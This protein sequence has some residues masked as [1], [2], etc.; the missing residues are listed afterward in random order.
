M[1]S[2]KEVAAIEGLADWNPDHPMVKFCEN[3]RMWEKKARQIACS[4]GL[5]DN[6][7]LR[8]FDLGCGFG[9]FVR[10]CTDL[11]HDAE[12]L[13]RREPLMAGG[14]NDILGNR[15]VS[16]GVQPGYPVPVEFQDADLITMFGVSLRRENGDYW[17]ATEYAE[18]TRDILSRLNKGGRFVIRP[19]YPMTW[20]GDEWGCR[21]S[22]WAT[23]EPTENTITVRPK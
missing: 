16:G 6:R 12:G 13:D 1:L 5:D 2:D 18:L 8:I 17:D 14:A 23:I 20:N 22:Q 9:Y 19:N 15:F 7:P 21:V 10:V 4:L 3:P 11:G